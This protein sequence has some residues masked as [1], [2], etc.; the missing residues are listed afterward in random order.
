MDERIKVYNVVKQFLMRNQDIL[1]AL[2]YLFPISYSNY[3]IYITINIY[4]E[5]YFQESY[6]VV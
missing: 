2:G 3:L 1:K 5:L 4:M 6:K